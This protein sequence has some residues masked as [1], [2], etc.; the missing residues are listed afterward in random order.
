MSIV[1]YTNKKTGVRT[2]YESESYWDK[3]LKQPRNRRK[4]L[5]RVDNNGNIIPSSG[6]RGRKPGSR[7]V[8]KEFEF[9]EQNDQ[10]RQILNEKD[11]EIAGLRREIRKLRSS[12]NS[13]A[14]ILGQLED[15][16]S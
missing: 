12:L 4:Y 11:K 8:D 6:K 10:L 7:V 15:E 2:A 13:I 16:E 1:I 14:K 3:E 9:S 5:G